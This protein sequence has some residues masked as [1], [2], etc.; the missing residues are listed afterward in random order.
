[1]TAKQRG[2][3]LETLK[4]RFDANS[5]RHPGLTWA[6]VQTR[7]ESNDATLWSL[8]ETSTLGFTTVLAPGP[9][10]G[11]VIG[12]SATL[13]QSHLSRECRS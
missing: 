10:Q 4:A 6:D 7:L 12:T 2:S 8:G 11:A 5:Q 1:M 13:D 9:A 3:L